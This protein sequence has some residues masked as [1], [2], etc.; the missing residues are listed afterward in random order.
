M[1]SS[2]ERQTPHT[3]DYENP[4]VDAAVVNLSGTLFLQSINNLGAR[5]HSILRRQGYNINRSQTSIGEEVAIETTK[6]D[7]QVRFTKLVVE[8]RAAFL[9]LIPKNQ[10]GKIVL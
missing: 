9:N 3:E 2:A 6:G 7:Y 5:A 4:T 10:D 1:P 8:K